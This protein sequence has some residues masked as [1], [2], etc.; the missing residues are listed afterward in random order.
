[1]KQNLQTIKNKWKL[2]QV[3]QQNVWFF[4]SV[5]YRFHFLSVWIIESILHHIYIWN[6]SKIHYSHG[7]HRRAFIFCLFRLL[8]VIL[9]ADNNR[10]F[11]LHIR[12][13][14]KK[15]TDF[16]YLS[17]LTWIKMVEKIT[18]IKNCLITS[19]DHSVPLGY[20][21]YYQALTAKDFEN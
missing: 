5:W 1:M 15:C 21:F 19:Q 20:F 11:E 7:H 3:K 2:Q 8:F 9:C 17:S 6:L 16:L 14:E 13:S 10:L 18:K 4:Y 12:I